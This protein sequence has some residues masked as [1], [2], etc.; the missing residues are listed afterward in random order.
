MIA[1]GIF[2]GL[3]AT[4]ILLC[5]SAA[6][7]FGLWSAGADDRP[8]REMSAATIEVADDGCG[9]IRSRFGSPPDGLQWTITDQG[10]FQVLG[11]NAL[12]EDR[13]RYYGQGTYEVVLEAYNGEKSVEVSNRVEIKC[14]GR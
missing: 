2:V 4:F 9:V 14:P 13:Y 8:P 11:R 3:G 1:L 12:N 10:G 7:I 6:L 5:I